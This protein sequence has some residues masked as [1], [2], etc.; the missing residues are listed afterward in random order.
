MMH[1]QESME[2]REIVKYV[3]AT[4]QYLRV[5]EGSSATPSNKFQS[6]N[7]FPML[8]SWTNMIYFMS[9]GRVTLPQPQHT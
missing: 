2:R 3:Y 4:V 1:F 7:A 8:V 5:S 6:L 9:L